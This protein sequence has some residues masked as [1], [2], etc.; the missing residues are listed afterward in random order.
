MIGFLVRF[1]SYIKKPLT[2]APL[3]LTKNPLPSKLPPTEE[4]K[5]L[6][7]KIISQL[8]SLMPKDYSTFFDQLK[9]ITPKPCCL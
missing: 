7:E 2:N 1:S 3:G 4:N 5:E 8:S 6:D 9:K